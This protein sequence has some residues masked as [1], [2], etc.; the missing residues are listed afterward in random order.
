M[1]GGVFGQERQTILKSLKETARQCA[2][3]LGV[4]KTSVDPLARAADI[5]KGA[6]YKFYASK[7]NCF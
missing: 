5:S 7:E 4:H 3:S 2:L 6:F 1:C